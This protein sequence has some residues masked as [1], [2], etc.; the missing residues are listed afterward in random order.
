[1]AGGRA[2]RGY[3]LQYEETGAI[4]EGAAV[5]KSK[6]VPGDDAVQVRAYLEHRARGLKRSRAME[7]AGVN[8]PASSLVAMDR[9]ALVYAGHTVWNR[10]AERDGGRYGGG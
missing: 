3:R 7:L 8:W 9:N 5:T 6:L 4:R 1:R 10:S 2:P